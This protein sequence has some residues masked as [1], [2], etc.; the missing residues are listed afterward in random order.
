MKVVSLELTNNKKWDPVN[1]MEI[2]YCAG[3]SFKAVKLG[4]EYRSDKVYS[5]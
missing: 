1:H 3:Y 2:G 4:I 5:D